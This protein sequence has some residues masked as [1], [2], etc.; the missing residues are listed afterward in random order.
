MNKEKLLAKA[1]ELIEK[2]NEL[3]ELAN[4]EDSNV[5]LVPDNIKIT[6]W[7]PGNWMWIINWEQELCYKYK[8]IWI[9]TSTWFSDIIKCKL[10]PCK[11]EDLEPW[12]IFYRDSSNFPDFDDLIWY[13]IKLE[14]WYQLWYNKD[15]NYWDTIYNYHWKVEQL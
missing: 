7:N 12:D 8:W 6:K 1:D 13:A 5:I 15:C 11:Y 14:E 3:K 2:A 4:K 9:V 10:T